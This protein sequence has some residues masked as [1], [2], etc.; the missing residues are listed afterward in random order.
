MALKLK[1]P[2]TFWGK[3][4]IPVPGAEKAAVRMEFAHMNRS[5]VKAFLERSKDRDD[6][7]TIMEIVRN[8]KAE[9]V[10]AEFSRAA[11]ELLCEEYVASPAAIVQ[12]WLLELTQARLGN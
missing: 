6:V 2:D 10:D 11:V 3:A 1:A 4:M 12:A 8:W 5:G 9:D 7:E